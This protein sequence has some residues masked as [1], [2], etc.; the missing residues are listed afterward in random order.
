MGSNPTGAL[1]IFNY[2]H[3]WKLLIESS[4][5]CDLAL[6]SKGL[7]FE[8]HAWSQIKDKWEVYTAYRVCQQGRWCSTPFKHRFRSV[9]VIT[10]ASHAEDH[11]FEPGRKHSFLFRFLTSVTFYWLHVSS[12]LWN[13]FH[14]IFNFKGNI[15]SRFG[16][17]ASCNQPM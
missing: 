4:C 2:R 12:S 7:I 14:G 1:E 11:R 3:F 16:A 17:Y 9:V 13:V 5:E 6:S 8:V 10:S 15:D